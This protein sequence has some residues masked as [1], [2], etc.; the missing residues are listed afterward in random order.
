MT[1]KQ[2]R[3]ATERNIASILTHAEKVAEKISYRFMDVDGLI[4]SRAD[5]LR[6]QVRS[7]AADLRKYMAD[8]LAE[9]LWEI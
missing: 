2:L 5:D 8:C 4:D 1:P 9:N 6:N 7:W 3:A